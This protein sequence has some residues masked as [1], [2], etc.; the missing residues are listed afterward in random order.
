MITQT[1]WLDRK[2]VFNLPIGT[3]PP[4]LERLRGTP[5]RA[6]ELVTDLPEHMLATRV[7]DKWSVK[8]HLGHLVDLAPLDRRRLGEFLDRVEV[9]SAADMENR[10]TEIAD[11]RSVP[12]A[13]I[14]RQLTAGREALLRRLAVLTEEQIRIFAV[15][16]RVQRPMRLVDWVYFVAEHDDHHLAQ[17]RMAITAGQD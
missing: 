13:E 11:H 16:P 1:A 8:E 17:A 4:L 7:D 14:I 10:A 9:L 12:I 3:F 2:F 5:A 6:K 15:H